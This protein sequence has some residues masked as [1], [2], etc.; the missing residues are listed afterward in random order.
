MTDGAV[1]P[2]TG[3]LPFKLYEVAPYVIDA[4]LGGMI[5]GALTMNLGTWNKLPSDLQGLFSQLGK[6]YGEQ[7]VQKVGAN[8]TKHFKIIADKGAKISDMAEGE[9]KKW[10]EMVPDIAGEWAAR[11]EEGGLPAKSILASYMDGVR[12]R[13]GSPL[14]NWGG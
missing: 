6:E 2:G 10:V 7:V 9:I 13:G 3:I 14:R 4:K 11:V 5:S 1:L 8:R 12:K